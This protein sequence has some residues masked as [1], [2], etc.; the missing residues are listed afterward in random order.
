[1]KKID[2]ELKKDEPRIMKMVG[3]GNGKKYRGNSNNTNNR[4]VS[5]GTD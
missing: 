2:K 4:K 1:M 3:K 5:E